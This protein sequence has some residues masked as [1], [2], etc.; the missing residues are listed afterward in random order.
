MSIGVSVFCVPWLRWVQPRL[1]RPIRVNL[2][3]PIFYI[4]C[5]LFIVA[6]PMFYEPVDTGKFIFNY[7]SWWWILM[8]NFSQLQLQELVVLW[9]W[10]LYLFTLSL[11]L[12][13][14]NQSAS[15]MLLVSLSILISLKCD[16]FN[17]SRVSDGWLKQVFF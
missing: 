15:S 9:S 8:F 1:E 12:G 3:F 5:T 7:L 6:V 10:P 11:S 17:R 4:A 2:F 16:I 14:I 13:K